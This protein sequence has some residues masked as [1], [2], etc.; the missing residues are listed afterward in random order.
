V[1]IVVKI[2]EMPYDEKDKHILDSQKQLETIALPI[3]K[4][5]LGD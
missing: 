2:K 5:D 3:V 4:E 1:K